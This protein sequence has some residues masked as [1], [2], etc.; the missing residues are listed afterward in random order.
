MWD[1]P[2]MAT[3]SE[4]PRGSAY[5]TGI[6]RFNDVHEQ[7]G[8]HL[9]LLLS[10]SPHSRDRK[11]GTKH[12]PV[13]H[14]PGVYLFTEDHEHRYV[15]RAKDLNN[16]FGQHVAPCSRHNQAGYAFNIAKRDAECAGFPV[17]GFQREHLDADVEFNDRFFS[18]AK[19]RVR[20]MEF[21]FALFDSEMPD[22]D[23]LSTIFEVYVSLLF[24]TEG[25]FNL[26]ATH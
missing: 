19:A 25:D 10:C 9:H 6:A 26:F 22:V 4:Q 18:P 20:A 7:L 11:P 23:A 2:T 5:D 21:R 8:P 15:G 1:D 13:P 3:A 12:I 16:R 14:Q 24:G 17:L